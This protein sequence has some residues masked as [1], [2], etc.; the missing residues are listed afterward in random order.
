MTGNTLFPEPQP[1]LAALTDSTKAFS[2]A[3]ALAKTRDKVKVAIKNTLRADLEITLRNLAN[4]CAFVAKG[5]RAQLVSSGFPV[6]TDSVSPAALS[7]P[8]NFT[9]QAGR[10]SGELIVSVNR[11]RNANAYL[12]LYKLASADNGAWTHAAHSL[13][14]FT[15]TRLEVLQPYN[16]KMGAI[17]SRGQ[18]VYTDTITKLV[19]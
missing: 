15:L 4:Y 2:D 10:H 18:T 14:Y 19:V 5:D 8:E 11:I 16:F 12:L 9:A 7:T 6:S 13:P 1:T 17:G 3:L